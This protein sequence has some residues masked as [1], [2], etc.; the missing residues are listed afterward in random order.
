MKK[1]IFLLAVSL[2]SLQFTFAKGLFSNPEIETPFSGTMDTRFGY[3][4]L[5]WGA[6]YSETEKAGYPLLNFGIGPVNLLAYAPNNQCYLGDIHKVEG[7]DGYDEFYSHGDVDTTRFIF[8]DKKFLVK[9]IDVL[10]GKN[11]SFEFLHKRYGTFSEKDVASDEAKKK[12]IKVYSN[13]GSFDDPAQYSLLITIDKRGKTEVTICDYLRLWTIANSPEY[14]VTNAD[15]TDH[16]GY[17]RVK[18]EPDT[19]YCYACT[20]STSKF[21]DYTFVN[22]NSDGKYLFV[23]YT[24]V[25]DA[26]AR[27]Y[28]RAGICWLKNTSGTY[29]I[30]NSGDMISTKFSSA[31]WTSYSNDKRYTYTWNEGQSARN[32]INLFLSNE[33][34]TVRH[35]DVISVFKNC[36]KLS[37]I[38]GQF[39]ITTE[40]IDFALANEEF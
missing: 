38:I 7:S 2:L 33:T 6:T 31:Y 19:W 24:K 14:D 11:P 15:K 5:K 35:N 26:S 9:V 21:F 12:G 8:E 36:N 27:S 17:S 37:D 34:L 3:E 22:Q 30:K 13:R 10:K 28:L 40:E 39:G 32:M 18:P 16:Y 1:R 4:S 23:G 20:D 29:E 25:A